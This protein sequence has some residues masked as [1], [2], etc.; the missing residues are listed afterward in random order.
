MTIRVPINS[1]LILSQ[2]VVNS[3]QYDVRLWI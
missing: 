2:L 1:S 3:T